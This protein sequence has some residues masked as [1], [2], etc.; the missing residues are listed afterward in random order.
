MVET[1]Q[2]SEAS[3][4]ISVFLQIIGLA[5]PHA[6]KVAFNPKDNFYVVTCLLT[7]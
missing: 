1:K 7:I 3:L 2:V 6:V 5:L 4:F